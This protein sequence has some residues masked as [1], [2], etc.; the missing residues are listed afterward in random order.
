VPRDHRG[1]GV[2]PERYTGKGR[3]VP[4][5]LVLGLPRCPCQTHLQ[6]EHVGSKAIEYLQSGTSKAT[7]IRKGVDW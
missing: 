1:D 7:S 3:L 4:L 5:P 6:Q 2:A